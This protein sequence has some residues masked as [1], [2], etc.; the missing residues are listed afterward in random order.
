MTPRM[1]IG[2][3]VL[4]LVLRVSPALAQQVSAGIQVLDGP[5]AAHILIGQPY[6]SR[7]L[8]VYPRRRVVVVE[9]YAPRVLA[10]ERLHRGNGYWR[11]QRFHRVYAY[12]DCDR[13][14][15]YDRSDERYPGLRQVA[16]YERDGRFYRDDRGERDHDWDH[17]RG[18]HD[19]NDR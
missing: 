6:G 19:D 12:Y 16:L 8:A 1:M 3:V 17:D 14:V 5:V 15:Y 10:V 13:D 7:P 18:W 9:H 11:H 4:G 2:P